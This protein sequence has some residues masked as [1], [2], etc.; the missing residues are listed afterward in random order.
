MCQGWSRHSIQREP[1]ALECKR[2]AV[3]TSK[4][5]FTLH[6]VDERG[7]PILR[8]DLG[9]ARF[10]GFLGKIPSTEVVLEACGSSH[11]WGRVAQALGH[12]VRL[13]PPQY[14]KPFVKRGKNDRN[15]AEAIGEAASRPSC[16]VAERYW[17]Q[18]RWAVEEY[19]WRFDGLDRA[20]LARGAA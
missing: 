3:D 7:R 12:K 11:H 2:I 9:R 14:V 19:A 16:L 6:G 15:D 8:R 18:A 13:I 1:S 10:E 17:D 5:V 20:P 4:S